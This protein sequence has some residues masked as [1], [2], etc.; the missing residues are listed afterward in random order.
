M[1]TINS[2]LGTGTEA[3]DKSLAGVISSEAGREEEQRSMI[4]TLASAG[5]DILNANVLDSPPSPA[6]DSGSVPPSPASPSGELESE[7]PDEPGAGGPETSYG[8]IPQNIVAGGVEGILHTWNNLAVPAMGAA[9]EAEGGTELG[10]SFRENFN[11]DVE[12]L[13]NLTVDVDGIPRKVWPEPQGAVEGGAKGISQFLTTFLPVF[14]VAGGVQWLQ[15]YEKASRFKSSARGAFAGIF[16]DALPFDPW[17]ERLTDIII[18]NTDEDRGPLESAILNFMATDP[19]DSRA[20]AMLKRSLEGLGVGIGVEAAGRFA[21]GASKAT[22]KYAAEEVANVAARVKHNRSMPGRLVREGDID[23]PASELIMDSSKE[24]THLRDAFST[25]TELVERVKNFDTGNPHIAE[26]RQFLKALSDEARR[27][28]GSLQ[29]KV[30]GRPRSAKADALDAGDNQLDEGVDDLTVEVDDVPDVDDFDADDFAELSEGEVP[31]FDLED[32]VIDVDVVDDI[33]LGVDGI[34][35]EALEA[36]SPEARLYVESAIYQDRGFKNS[37]LQSFDAL[38]GPEMR[39]GSESL[40]S[41]LEGIGDGVF[42]DMARGLRSILDKNGEVTSFLRGITTSLEEAEEK[43]F[44]QATSDIVRKLPRNIQ[45]DL[46]NGVNPI[47]DPYTHTHPKTV[48]MRNKLKKLMDKDSTT[49]LEV[50]KAKTAKSKADKVRQETR[51]ASDF[52]FGS[53]NR[54]Q[55]A[56]AELDDLLKI[57]TSEEEIDAAALARFYKD[58]DIVPD[59]NMQNITNGEEL[60]EVFSEMSRLGSKSGRRSLALR[61]FRSRSMDATAAAAQPTIDALSRLIRNEGRI[62]GI[63]AANVSRWLDTWGNPESTK[64]HLSELVEDMHILRTMNANIHASVLYY[65]EAIKAQKGTIDVKAKILN[66]IEVA[67][68]FNDLVS[69]A[70]TA[71]GRGLQIFN[72]PIGAD[73]TLQQVLRLN[74]DFVNMTDKEWDRWAT[75][76]LATPSM[77]KRRKLMMRKPGMQEMVAELFVNNIISGTITAAVNVSAVHAVGILSPI[78]EL[79][80]GVINK[81]VWDRSA[82]EGQWG[83]DVMDQWNSAMDEILGT[84]NGYG[85]V[86]KLNGAAG[87]V[88]SMTRGQK[89]RHWAKTT[90]QTYKG[91]FGDMGRAGKR[92]AKTFGS[93]ESTHT[94]AARQIIEESRDLPSWMKTLMTGKNYIDPARGARATELSGLDPSSQLAASSANGRLRS[95]SSDNVSDLLNRTPVIGKYN[96]GRIARHGTLGG[97]LVD[98]FGVTS[99]LAARLVSTGDEL[100]KGVFYRANLVKSA[101]RNARDA[102][103]SGREFHKYVE[104]ATDNVPFWAELDPEDPL[105]DAYELLHRDA[106]EHARTVT[107]TNP[108]NSQPFMAIQDGISKAP[109]VKLFVPFIRTPTN[110]M[111][112][113]GERTP[114]LYKATKKYRNIQSKLET[115]PTNKQAKRELELFQAHQT[116]GNALWG[117]AFYLGMDGRISG[118]GPTNPHERKIKEDTGWQP[119]SILVGTRA[120][121]S[122]R[123]VSYRRLDPFATF[124]A[125]AGTTAERFAEVQAAPNGDVLS[126]EA[127]GNISIAMGMIAKDKSFFQGASDLIDLIDPRRAS[128]DKLQRWMGKTGAALVVPNLYASLS[129]TGIAGISDAQK[130]LFEAETVMEHIKRRAGVTD[131][132]YPSRNLYG[133]VYARPLAM[134]PDFI[135]PLFTNSRKSSPLKDFMAESHYGADLR[136]MRED[137][138]GFPLPIRMRDRLARI[139][140]FLIKRE[141]EA[142][143]PGLKEL[144][145]EV[146]SEGLEGGRL[147]AIRSIVKKKMREAKD[148][149]AAGTE[150]GEPGFFYTLSPEGSEENKRAYEEAELFKEGLRGRTHLEAMSDALITQTAPESGDPGGESAF[151][152]TLTEQEAIKEAMIPFREKGS[153]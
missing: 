25:I 44:A 82:I 6:S 19:T 37:V 20:E 90:G 15:R 137:I 52:L 26:A 130:S 121:G 107:F 136:A 36:L 98:A 109:I 135:S 13:Q 33:D 32:A 28:G 114:V 111:K 78:S 50:E 101:R 12:A 23:V 151:T 129:A 5:V 7:A 148:L 45:T 116:A 51:N 57:L 115:D 104:D 58:H 77:R 3:E 146:E 89:L 100:S 102:G 126:L 94:N 84:I 60:F 43:W 35:L 73:G 79:V 34:P 30:S 106:I 113:V 74:E 42:S 128:N 122:P 152:K 95:I 118:A 1:T 134:G 120:D 72:F 132:L 21:I 112:Y 76:I 22:Y 67:A 47:R 61:A 131:G 18:D 70:T 80:G 54:L 39:E 108:L 11:V 97:K 83:I 143:L 119:F 150:M 40:I 8:G 69:G 127:A 147:K 17:E 110:L 55:I 62:M 85:D 125:L 14:R 124:L 81:T 75:Q 153:E 9:L 141:L 10:D 103:L 71:M 139:S 93:L 65:A 66:L 48:E 96:P 46:L 88:E 16:G 149:V 86:L 105:R 31:D 138:G 4:S 29:P 133:E 91:G 87:Y 27:N 68:N 56:D 92:F 64:K 63:P 123:W 2:G 53:G 144:G 117:T 99:N 140:G 24:V 41:H 38:V 59:I 145:M 142:A 49:P